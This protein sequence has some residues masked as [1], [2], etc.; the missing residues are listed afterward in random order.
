MSRKA[1]PKS[2][3]ISCRKSGIFTRAIC[4]G[5]LLKQPGS[6]REW[7]TAR[8]KNGFVDCHASDFDHKLAYL[9][10]PDGRI[11]VG[12]LILMCRPRQYEE[13]ARAYEKRKAALNI[14]QM[15]QS[16]AERGVDGVSMPGGAEHESALRQN[17]HRQ[18][19][20]PYEKER[21]PE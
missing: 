10:G 18:S 21:V 19:Y 9:A 7:V 16:H 12:G 6:R 14:E 2:R 13:Q 3:A 17:R 11:V 5:L 1:Q 4:N 20:V 8:Q 15:K